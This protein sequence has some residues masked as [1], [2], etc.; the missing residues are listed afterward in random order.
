MIRYPPRLD[1]ALKNWERDNRTSPEQRQK[2][3]YTILVE[4]LA[5]QFASPVQW[6]E[7]QDLLFPHDNF[8]RPVELGPGPTLT[9]VATRSLK[10]KYEAPDD[11]V[12]SRTWAIYCH[13]K[14]EV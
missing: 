3:V 10:A 1:K 5:Y 13:A 4:P 7:T 9:G 2:L 14:H 12:S 8:E 6:I 11:S